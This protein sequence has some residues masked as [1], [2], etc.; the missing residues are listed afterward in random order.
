VPPSRRLRKPLVSDGTSIR[1]HGKVA[2]LQPRPGECVVAFWIDHPDFR[3]AFELQAGPGCDG[4]FLYKAPGARPLLLLVELKGSGLPKA[5]EQLGNTLE[6]LKSSF[7]LPPGQYRAVVVTD[8]GVP[9]QEKGR[10]VDFERR[11]KMRLEVSRDGDLRRFIRD[12][13]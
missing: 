5:V 2:R 6:V 11:H 13:Q 1:E 4:L 7:P 3:T 12:S 10:L 8:R 9:T